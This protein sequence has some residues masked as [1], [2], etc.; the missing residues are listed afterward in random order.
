MLD[1]ILI[2]GNED[3]AFAVFP[4]LMP[5][6]QLPFRHVGEVAEALEQ[7]F[8]GV[9]FLHDHDIIH[10]DACFFN[11]LVD[12][13]K[14]VPGGWHVG[15]EYC[16]EDGWTRFKWTR[17]WLTRPNKYYLIDYDSSVRVKAEGDQWI[18]GNWGQDRSVPEMRWDEAC[19]GYK[20]DVYQMGNMIND[21]IEDERTP[22]ERFWVQHYNFLLQRGYKLRP[23]YDPQ[24]IPSWIVDTS[25][26]ATL[27]ED[28][29]ASLYAF[30]VL[31]AVRVSDGKK[32]ILKKVNT[33][34]EELSILRDLSEPHVQNDPR[35]HSIPLLDVIPIPGDDDLAFAVFPP[36]MQIDQ[37]PFRHVGEVA[38]ALDQLFEGVAFLH[39]HDI[40]HGD[41][42]FFNFLVDPSKMV[43]KGW[44]FGAEY[45]EE[46]G[47]TRIKWTRRWLTR[48]NKYYLI[49]YDLSVRVKAE[50]D[51]WMEGQWGQDRTVPEMTGHEA[52]NGYK[53]DV[54]QMGNIINNLI[55]ASSCLRLVIL[56]KDVLIECFDST[57]LHG[58]GSI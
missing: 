1:T 53:V 35:C 14:M 36:L 41:A 29:I 46:D 21:L 34:T 10:G 23:R 45:C 52:C 4:V 19:D 43:P 44:H 38:E 5:I 8:E 16:Q 12:A 47:L 30:W 20:V 50:G 28:S 9:A 37:L 55:E 32:V 2:P 40:I 31:D 42:C 57:G 6:D 15:A 17:R 33:Y 26:L 56:E 24:W 54:Y 51:Q 48:P 22:S 39:E 25:R 58:T 18:A 3:M 11:F 13:S 27:S 49:D 7:L